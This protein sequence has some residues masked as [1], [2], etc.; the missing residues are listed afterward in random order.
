MSNGI[1]RDAAPRQHD[2]GYRLAELLVALALLAVVLGYA[3]GGIRFGTR[4]WQA[5][6]TIELSAELGA[7]RTVLRS[8]LAHTLPVSRVLASGRFE[9][10]FRGGSDRLMIVCRA[11][12]AVSDGAPL[13]RVVLAIERNDLVASLRDYQVREPSVDQGASAERHVLAHDVRGLAI[14]YFGEAEPGAGDKWHSEWAATNRLPELVGI[15]LQL[16]EGDRRTWPEL[17]VALRARRG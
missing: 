16:S 5:T 2:A 3:A 6:Q 8:C 4:A 9:L 13:E 15:S 7:A 11:G 1:I 10:A 14:R 12:G 17:V